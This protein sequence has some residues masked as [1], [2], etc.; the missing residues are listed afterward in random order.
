MFLTR[1]Q[2]KSVQE[3]SLELLDRT[4]M[5]VMNVPAR[6]MMQQAGCN[7]SGERVRIPQ[8]IVRR[9]IASVPRTFRLHSRDGDRSFVIGGKNV[10]FNPGSS[11][12]TFLDS[13]TKDIRPGTA[14]DLVKLV[15]VADALEYIDAQSTALIPT[16]VPEKIQDLYRLNLVLRNS[17]KPIV[18]GA[19]TKEGLLDM[20]HMLEAAVGSPE[21][22]A[23]KP[24]AIFDCC[25]VSPLTWGDITPQNLMD[26]AER[27]VPAEIIPAP[28]MGATSPVTIFGT[29]IQSNAEVL[30]G[31]VISQLKRP[32]APV[33]Y[34]GSLALF[35]MKYGM[36]CLGAIETAMAACASAEIGKSYRIPT[37]A[38]LGL[39]DSKM[40]DAQSGFES[41]IG[42]LLAGIT[43]INVVSG[44]GMLAFENCQS[45]EKLAIDNEICGM[46]KRLLRG[47][48]TE[49]VGSVLSLLDSV[50]PRGEFLSAD[51]TLSKFRSEQFMPS[52]ITCRRPVNSWKELGGS[53]AYKRASGRVDK[54]LSVHKP[55]TLPEARE[56]SLDGA[57]ASILKKHSVS[58]EALPRV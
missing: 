35:D 40:P 43:G 9:A 45:T 27:M 54:I 48:E 25:P 6:E 33:V 44:P 51:H 56:R 18:T 28:M 15:K 55:K 23:K 10:M 46:V 22:L 47:L 57:I 7:V 34:G 20:V 29:L 19:F 53:D 42:L 38:Y 31:I 32:N 11:A 17:D 39:S 16:D 1:E 2:I 8:D 41:A 21:D 4:G 50:G 37:Q 52:D 14:A 36:I 26:C 13:S 24:R 58:P 12:A 3:A 5:A 30:S 49:D